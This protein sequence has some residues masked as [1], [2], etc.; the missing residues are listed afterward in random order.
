MLLFKKFFNV[1]SKQIEDECKVNAWD[2]LGTK[3]I[4]VPAWKYLD[5][6]GENY[7]EQW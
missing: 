5:V 3:L 6:K 7:Q 2:D 4:E 1:K